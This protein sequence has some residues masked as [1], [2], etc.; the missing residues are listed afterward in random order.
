[1]ARLTEDQVNAIEAKRA[2]ARRI[3]DPEERKRALQR[4]TQEEFDLM[5]PD[6]G[7]EGRRARYADDK[8]AV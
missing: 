8:N 3:Q 6:E 1:M 5:G 2:E 4:V 7:I